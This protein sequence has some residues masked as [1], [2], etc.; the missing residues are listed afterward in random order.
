[1]R[2]LALFL[3]ISILL[4]LSSYEGVNVLVTDLLVRHKPQ[5]TTEIELVENNQDAPKLQEKERPIIH[6]LEP[7]RVVKSTA[8]AR[9]DSE[10][11]QRVEKETKARE[12]GLS[13]NK[14]A[15]SISPFPQQ[16]KPISRTSSDN[17][18][19]ALHVQNKAPAAATSKVSID[20]PN[21]I[22]MSDATNL[23]TDANI[24]YS[25]YNRV[26]ELFYVRWEERLNYYWNRLSSDFKVNTLA[27]HTWRTT[28]EIVLKA[29]GEYD[30]STILQSCGYPPFD[31]AA[32]FAFKNARYF[33]NVPKAK[34]E[35]DGYVRLKYRFSV[36][37][38]P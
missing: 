32:I 34:V 15:S 11:K 35:S 37:V 38:G 4:H 17:P 24:Y 21:D 36:R 10:K 1:M 18:E 6:Q 9:F 13:R 16:M 27:G 31:E 19:F 3:F 8:P 23:N 25:F 14:S 2:N 33:P 5:P 22:Q 12:L 7:A 29:S 30:S 26:E 28:F 20:L